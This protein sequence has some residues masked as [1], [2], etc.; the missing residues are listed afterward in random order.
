LVFNRPFPTGLGRGLRA[1]KG[2][3][4]SFLKGNHRGGPTA[5]S[6]RFRKV[7]TLSRKKKKGADAVGKGATE[8]GPK[9]RKENILLRC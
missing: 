1:P 8:A 6:Q 2:G 3:P 9:D 4:K 5:F 7:R